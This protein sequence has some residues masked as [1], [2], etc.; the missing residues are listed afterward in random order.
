MFGLKFFDSNKVGQLETSRGPVC[1]LDNLLYSLKLVVI[2]RTGTL[3][4][5]AVKTQNT[6]IVDTVYLLLLG[7][8]TG[9]TDLIVS[10]L[11][12]ISTYCPI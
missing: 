8:S 12:Y 9:F 5:E 2:P 3:E 11:S 4:V 10:A 1:S 7:A 6:N